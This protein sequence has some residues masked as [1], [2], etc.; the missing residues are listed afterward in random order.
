MSR[1]SVKSTS[2][3]HLHSRR[4]HKTITAYTE[5]TYHGEEWVLKCFYVLVV[6]WYLVSLTEILQGFVANKLFVIV[7]IV[8]VKVNRFRPWR[9]A[10]ERKS[11]RAPGVVEARAGM[12]GGERKNELWRTSCG[13][14]CCGT[15]RTSCGTVPQRGLMCLVN[16]V[17]TLTCNVKSDK[18]LHV[19]Y[20]RLSG[21][22][23]LSIEVWRVTVFYVCMIEWSWWSVYMYV[24]SPCHS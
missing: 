12:N 24:R 16:K 15:S 17:K 14:M 2:I 7:W 22:W 21:M 9:S 23:R 13:R 6:W 11:E 10:E 19:R 18:A 5:D 3:T 1:E 20:G 4:Q 8:I